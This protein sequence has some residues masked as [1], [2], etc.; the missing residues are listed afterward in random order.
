[1]TNQRGVKENTRGAT[2]A[3]K[4]R[5][6]MTPGVQ[7]VTPDETVASAATMMAENDVGSLPVV[8]GRTLVGMLTDRDIVM[9]AVARG[10]DMTTVTVAEV[11]SGA[12]HA[13]EPDQDL[14]DALREMAKHQVRRLPVVEDGELVGILAQ[15]DV[16]IVAKEKEAGEMLEEISQPSS[17]E[18][19]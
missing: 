5:E 7:C 13:V 4:V 19:G 15:A 9:R 10:A 1:V 14:D 18:R 17:L 6:A 12:V 8:E 16:A 2:M 3:T 11:A